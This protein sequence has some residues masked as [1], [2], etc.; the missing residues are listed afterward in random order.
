MM[1]VP[2]IGLVVLAALIFRE[3]SGLVYEITYPPMQFLAPL[4]G[5]RE[6][7][8]EDIESK[9]LIL[10]DY[11]DFAAEDHLTT[12]MESLDSLKVPY[13]V[14]DINRGRPINFQ[15]HDTIILSLLDYD[16]ITPSFLSLM[17]WVE[18][19]GSLLISIRPDPSDIMATSYRKFGTISLV[20]SLEETQGVTFETDLIPGTQGYTFGLDFLHH[21]S[22]P[23]N[24]ESSAI[25][26]LS[27]GDESKT[28]LVW[29][30]SLG[31][32][33]IVFINSDQFT[34]KVSRGMIATCY[35]LLFDAFAYPVINSSMFF[36]D[37]FPSPIPPGANE[38]IT[39]EFNRDIQ[40][41]FINVWWPDLQRM[42]HDYGIKFTG[43]IIETY[44]DETTPP[45]IKQ[46]ALDRFEYFGGLVLD[47]GGEIGLHGYNHVP[48]C[49]PSEDTN[50][51]LNYP[52]WDSTEAMELSIYELFSFSN[53]LFPDNEFS[54]YVPASNVLCSDVRQWLPR[55]LPDL[56]VIASVYLPGEEGLAYEQEFVE[57]DDGIVEMP[58][59]SSGFDISSYY[60]W[61]VINELAI[62]YVNSH[63]VHPG[64]VLHQIDHDT[65]WTDLMSDYEDF[66]KWLDQYAHGLRPMTARE[67]GMAVQRF[68]RVVLQRESH[69][70]Q[71]VIH[72]ENFYDEVQLL[73]RTAREPVEID[74]GK[75]TQVTS[76]LYLIQATENIVTLN[77]TE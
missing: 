66:I 45:F 11:T 39:Q 20:N 14:L 4:G 18:E 61:A 59:I 21:T 55:A 10:A 1:A 29:E 38:Y 30:H 28:P 75:I 74:G 56:R 60:L 42:T 53:N 57:A 46:A 52:D 8:I 44:V 33:K 19:G 51:I 68:D 32:G 5:S 2:L 41:F 64:D 16:K 9:T 12:V 22:F 7:S 17:D 58:R 73:V 77:F 63:Y 6:S 26:H 47:D 67:G 25:V 48:L 31:E 50:K 72:L 27:S 43:T 24:L 15:E 3:R 70:N 76:S 71:Y 34:T 37:D 13:V 36:I 54:T 65:G 23:V 40:G 62:H 35:S 49:P 69:D